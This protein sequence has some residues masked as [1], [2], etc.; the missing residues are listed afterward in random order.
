MSLS[1]S[2][3]ESTEE[4]IHGIA[5]RDPYRWLEDRSLPA[6]GEWVREQQMRCDA[7]FSECENLQALRLCVRS[8]LDVQAVDQPIRVGGRYFFRRRNRGEQQGS[9]YM[10]ER[11]IGIER[12]LV[13]PSD[14][15]PFTSVAVH[16][17][18]NDGSLL[19]YT[20][21]CGGEDA[22]VIRI[23][24]LKNGRIL[25]DRVPRG[26]A[27]GF[28]FNSESDGFYYCHELPPLTEDFCIRFHSLSQSL[29]DRILFSRPRVSSGRLILIADTIHLGALWVHES[30]SETAVDFYLARREEDGVWHKVFSNR[31]PTLRPILHCGRI[32]LFVCDRTTNGELIEVTRE[33]K[34]IRT[35]VPEDGIH[36]RRVATAEGRI[37]VETLR[38]GRPSIHSWTL[39]GRDCGEIDL[40]FEGT[41]RLL[42]PFLPHQES[43]FFSHES[44]TEPA[45][46]Y[47]YSI[48]EKRSTLFGKAGS[49]PSYRAFESREFWFPGRDR[50]AIPVTVVGKAQG[51]LDLPRPV[52]MTSYGGFG[53]TAK[54]QFSLLVLIMMELG[55]LFALPRIRGGGDF[56]HR[57]HEK[58]R[59][60]NR[61]TAIDDFLAA[62]AWLCTERVTSPERLAIFGGSNSG[63]LVG[64]A[65]T[66]RPALFRAVLCIA[67]LLDMVRYERF[68]QAAQWKSEYGTVSNPDDFRAL[69]GYSPYHRIH[70]HIDYPSTLFVSGDM[71]ER[72]NPA[73]VRKM[74]ALLQS[75]RGQHHPI[76]VDY[77]AER[78]H[79]PVL[80]L[81]VRVEALARRLAF[82]SR[83]LGIAVPQEA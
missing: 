69:I 71:D 32:F 35:V 27:R 50:T 20:T 63:L 12:L 59:G 60:R 28:T 37:F 55:A 47:E 6:T 36:P 49:Q 66:Q 77:S 76:L 43:L 13:D 52:I 39:E 5:V 23:Y 73:H 30:S 16:C 17:A 41:I 38:H 3:V 68:D 83:E 7:Y 70:P 74:A 64:A 24:S 65:M 81:T 46:I 48:A 45:W 31:R 62:A 80:P 44:F 9:L 51:G 34:P 61:Q 42:P 82:L 14:Q 79:S 57:W 4:V 22:K 40:P 11:T 33:G 21:Q 54:P 2:T 75:R 53:V 15:G 10:K 58:G 8:H 29:E 67:P 25:A 26:Y 1:P 18:S 56:G 78:G 72:C 19:A